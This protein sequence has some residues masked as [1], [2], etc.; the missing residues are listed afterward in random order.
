MASS[1]FSIGQIINLSR[2]TLKSPEIVKEGNWRNKE[3]LLRGH[4]LGYFKFGIFGLGRIGKN[5]AKF[6]NLFN[7][8]ISYFDP[9]IKINKYKKYSK[10][11]NFLRS[12]NF[13]IVTA[14]LTKETKCFFD[15]KRLNY[16]KKYSRILNISRGE[17]FNQKDL[18][19]V[20]KKK[21]FIFGT[22]VLSEES[23]ILKRKNS[24][25]N[26]FRINDDLVITPHMAGLTYESETKSITI[27]LKN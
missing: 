4:E 5:I 22:D 14:K 10:I 12:I 15:K 20:I 2:N 23:S 17:I 26:Y 18:Q 21:F 8:D 24:F 1:E 7:Y 19:N 9:Y 13:L 25:I 27:I 16:L 3:I 6:L 11:S